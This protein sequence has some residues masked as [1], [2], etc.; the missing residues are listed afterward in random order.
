MRPRSS[1]AVASAKTRPKPPI[2]NWP[3]CTKCQSLANPSVAEYW[4]IGDTTQRLRNATS[5]NCK[6]E[7]SREEAA[8]F[9]SSR[10][11]CTLEMKLPV[12]AFVIRMA[13]RDGRCRDLE[14]LQHLARRRLPLF[15]RCKRH[16]Q[17][18]EVR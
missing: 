10:P 15:G 5:R 6:G 11:F 3:R 2:A 9:S 8:A 4:H 16:P 14:E 17:Q 13:M 18:R 12:H 1:T 7:K